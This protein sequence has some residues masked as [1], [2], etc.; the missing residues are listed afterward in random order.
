MEREID[1]SRSKAM[2]LRKLYRLSGGDETHGN[3]DNF[4]TALN[5]LK[6]KLPGTF[7]AGDEFAIL[8]GPVEV[9]GDECD[10]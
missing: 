8:H 2:N 1:E 9:T 7:D 5:S 3:Y 6:E 4:L 10:E